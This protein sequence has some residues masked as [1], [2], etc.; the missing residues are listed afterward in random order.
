MNGVINWNVTD[1]G[2]SRDN[3]MADTVAL[4]GGWILVRNSPELSALCLSI[5]MKVVYR[6]AGDDPAHDPLNRVPEH[7]VD[8]RHAA[9]PIGCYIH[10]TNEVSASPA[11]NNW[12][13]RAMK[14]CEQL[15]RKAVIFNYSTHQDYA[16]WN[17]SRDVISYAVSKGHAIGVHV[18]ANDNQWEGAHNWY[19]LKRE[20]G[21]L[22]LMTEFG[23]INSIHDANNGWINRISPKQY[24][25]FAEPAVRQYG[26]DGIPVFFFSYE[27]WPNNEVGRQNGFG[28]IDSSE[29]KNRLKEINARIKVADSI[30]LDALGQPQDGTVTRVKQ[31]YVNLR[32]QPNATSK[33]IGDV[34][35]GDRVIYRP[36]PTRDGWLRFEEPEG[37]VAGWLLTVT[38]GVPDTPLSNLEVPFVSQIDSNSNLIN[39][40]CSE[41]TALTIYRHA[42]KEKFGVV[43]SWPTPDMIVLATDKARSD[44]S[45]PTEYIV[46]ILSKLAIKAKVVK[47]L[48]REKIVESI[49]NREK[50]VGVLVNYSLF[51]SSKNFGHFCTVVNVGAKGCWLHD[52]YNRNGQNVYV[53]W[54]ALE[55][56]MAKAAL[57]PQGVICE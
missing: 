45:K 25:V 41:A 34:T 13:M 3:V 10:L 42:I 38:P 57:S 35:L 46:E 20:L 18:Y 56:S 23:W 15:G 39:N 27:H 9:A 29:L 11:L 53:T 6:Q 5:G 4:G 51:D 22:W 49:I 50:P 31:T 55:A 26:L 30:N 47:G 48:K 24:A 28:A 19:P 17:I 36:L 40:D 7:F 14:R 2:I 43:P 52:P 33:D 16:S 32:Q 8:E 44:N 1:F 54:D 12:T 21:G 37:F